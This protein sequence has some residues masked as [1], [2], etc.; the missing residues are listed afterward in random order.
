MGRL[1]GIARRDK[2][3]APMETLESADISSAS[4]VA[5]DSRGKP[6]IRQ[7]TLLSARDWQAACDKLGN[8]IPWTVRRANLFI[9]EI[10]LPKAA[11][12]I[13]AIG[14]VRLRT[15]M[16]VAPCSRMDE[17]SPGLRQA[18]RADWRG[19]VAC[20]VIEGGTVSLGDNVSVIE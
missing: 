3:R 12:H 13:V 15:T 11:G 19:G 17:Q 8:E 6:G 9:D 7:V 4:G 10:D 14:S 20:E 5:G 1:A 2:K 18:L 16:E